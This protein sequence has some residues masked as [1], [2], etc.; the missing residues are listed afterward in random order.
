MA[1]DLLFEMVNIDSRTA[2]ETPADVYFKK[3][4]ISAYSCLIPETHQVA[5][6]V[7]FVSGDGGEE[8][9]QFTNQI[10]S[11]SRALDV[12]K[13]QEPRQPVLHRGDNKKSNNR[14]YNHKDNERNAG[15]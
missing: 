9:G 5:K 15:R 1:A 6:R 7:H 10:D 8:Y 11:T 14:K 13:D 4:T 12:F 3:G 2:M